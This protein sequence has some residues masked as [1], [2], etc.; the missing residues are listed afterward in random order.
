MVKLVAMGNGRV[1]VVMAIWVPLFLLACMTQLSMSSSRTNLYDG[2]R[3]Y[4]QWLQQQKQQQRCSN[5]SDCKYFVY[6]SDAHG[7]SSSCRY[8]QCI[9]GRC[10][11]SS[12]TATA[13]GATIHSQRMFGAATLTSA[14]TNYTGCNEGRHCGED[15]DCAKQCP[16]GYRRRVTCSCGQCWC[17]Y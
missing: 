7:S 14:D 8:G 11:C 13:S 17:G 12:N 1:V 2:V 10:G 5:I 6:S 16:K 9:G 4:D 15:A 3:D